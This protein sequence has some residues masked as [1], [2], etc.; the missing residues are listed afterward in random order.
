MR[1]HVWRRMTAVSLAMVTAVGLAACGS[2]SGSTAAT[3]TAAETGTEAAA[4]AGTTAD[5]AGTTGDDIVN[6]AF[7]DTVGTLNPLNMNW[8]FINYYATG[9]EFLPLVEINNDYEVDY[10]LAESI[11]TED[12][13]TFT[14]KLREDATWSDGEP[15]TADDVVWT[16][17]KFTCPAV[18]NPNFDFTPFVGINEDGTSPE[19]A[20]DVEGIKAIDDKTVQL[21]LHDHM[22]LKTMVNNSISWICILPQHVL[23]DTPDEELLTSAWFE[24]PDVV[25]GP[26]FV[27]DYDFSHYVSYTAN[28][29]YFLGTPSIK[30][31]NF[32]ILDSAEILTGLQSGEIDAVH[33][34]SSIP[35]EDRAAVEA[36]EGYTATYTE[37]I[38]NEM[39]FINTSKITDARV[40]QAIVY[41]IDRDT[42]VQALLQGHGEVTDGFTCSGSPYYSD[43]K[44][45]I[46]YDPDKARALLDEAGWDGSQTIQYYVSSSD[47]IVVK[48]AQLVQQYLS[49]VGIKME[50]NTVDFD[51][52]TGQI[53]GSDDEDMFSVQYTITPND[54]WADVKSLVDIPD[55]S[56]SGGYYNDDIDA[57]LAATQET[58][59]EAEIAEL[60]Y[61]IDEQVIADTPVFP[62]YFLSNLAVVS[63]RIQ[64]ADM[65]FY[66]AFNNIQE[67]TL[68][69]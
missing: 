27:E 69:D 7:T 68:A 22:N 40:R 44:T 18:A 42:I 8:N 67:W 36:L 54:Y 20:T 43:N 41:A 50:I 63:D 38:T 11:T 6:I 3:D 37:P 23:A 60:Y 25:S 59:D 1:A 31:V 56:W 45:K 15:I 30:K 57:W 26:Y 12:N 35:T 62:L 10:L 51:T 53:A 34:S 33:P 32:R 24:H 61:N 21:T 47:G 19:G 16:F 49:Q 64:G 66:G 2:S 58:T 14:I 29:N 39:T 28:E 55:S 48:A 52:L 65:T 5:A 9:M 4:E 46:T 17:M 13:Q